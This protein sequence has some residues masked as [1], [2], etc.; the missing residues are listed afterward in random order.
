M[1]PDVLFEITQ[2]HLDTGLR[3]FPVGYC[4]TSY[5][6]PQKGLFYCGK[7][8]AELAYKEP[9][10]VIYLEL[11]CRTFRSCLIEGGFLLWTDFPFAYPVDVV[12]NRRRR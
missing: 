12:N 2:E 1:K 4:P 5:V 9:K 11:R 8:I 6:D 3:G 10:E 7:S